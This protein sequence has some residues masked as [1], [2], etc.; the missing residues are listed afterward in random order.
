[1]N[2]KYLDA[3][4][5]FNTNTAATTTTGANSTLSMNNDLSTYHDA[6][7]TP[8]SVSGETTLNNGNDDDDNDEETDLKRFERS[9]PLTNVKTVN[10]NNSKNCKINDDNSKDGDGNGDDGN[11]IIGN[12]N[13]QFRQMSTN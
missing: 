12:L 7:E 6:Y 4:E 11:E 13:S 1:M 5:E 9:S 10:S 3:Q 2:D 8:P